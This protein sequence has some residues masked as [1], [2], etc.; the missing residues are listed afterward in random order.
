MLFVD[1]PIY[2]RLVS[3]RLHLLILLVVLL[4]LLARG[5]KDCR[6]H[7]KKSRE[8]LQLSKPTTKSW[9]LPALL[10]TW[11]LELDRAKLKFLETTDSRCQRGVPDRRAEAKWLL[12][13]L[14]CHIFHQKKRD[15]G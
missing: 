11:Q 5:W 2:A 4:E 6:T 15:Y 8:A 3:L 7:S 9:S 14:Y 1:A 13:F 12:T 10:A